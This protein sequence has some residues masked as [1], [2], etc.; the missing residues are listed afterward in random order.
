LK[1]W[2]SGER[3]DAADLR[4]LSASRETLNVEPP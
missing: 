4:N 1:I 3:V 2:P